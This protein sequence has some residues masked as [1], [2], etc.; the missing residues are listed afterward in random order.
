MCLREQEGR[1]K[2]RRPLPVGGSRARLAKTVPSKE[3]LLCLFTPFSLDSHLAALLLSSALSYSLS[4][5]RLLARSLAHFLSSLTSFTMRVQSTSTRVHSF[6]LDLLRLFT[7]ALLSS[8][9]LV[10]S[11]S[12]F[13]MSLFSFRFRFLSLHRSFSYYYT[14]IYIILGDTFL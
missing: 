11:S 10:D 1:T 2:K 13:V 12:R 4:L 14:K 7:L 5:S 6:H 3:S 8:L 9:F